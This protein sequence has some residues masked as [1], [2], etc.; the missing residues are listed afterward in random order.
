MLIETARFG[1]I[2]ALLAL[3]ACTSNESQPSMQAGDEVIYELAGTRWALQQLDGKPV[4]ISEGGREAYLYL[5]SADRS[6]VGH[7]GCNRISTTYQQNGAQISFG[8]VIATRMFCADMATETALLQALKVATGW[9]IDGSQL[10]LLD[11]QQ[12]TVARFE[13]RNL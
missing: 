2:A 8:D 4:K 13:A 7:A 3:A 12:T 11:G 10:D 1:I 9:R 6:V 5:N